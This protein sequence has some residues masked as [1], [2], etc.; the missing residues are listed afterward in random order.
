MRAKH[1]SEPWFS[2]VSTGNK[3]Y[4][5]RLGNNAEFTKVD[6]GATITWYN[7]DLGFR[8][9]VSTRITSKSR[10]K[11]FGAMLRSKGLSKVLPTVKTIAHGE[12]VYRHFYSDEKVAIHGVLCLGLEVVS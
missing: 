3:E 5:G 2:L 12:S 11:S 4:E 7:D 1:L 6:I 8:R 10:Y 9:D